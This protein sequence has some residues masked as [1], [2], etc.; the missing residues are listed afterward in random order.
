MSAAV[1][2]EFEAADVEHDLK[3][4]N[5]LAKKLRSKRYQTGF[6]GLES[7]RLAFDLDE[8]GMPIDTKN[9]ERSDSHKLIEEVCQ[10][11][12]CPVVCTDYQCF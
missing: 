4:L 12:E 8:N 7:L 3:I 10:T 5:D 6:L 2:Q 9:Y 1:H 11:L